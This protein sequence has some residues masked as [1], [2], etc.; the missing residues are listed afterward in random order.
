LASSAF[1]RPVTELGKARGVGRLA[2]DEFGY[3]MVDAEDGNI[4]VV[5]MN[6]VLAELATDRID[7][8]KCDI[9]GAEQEF[10]DNG[11]A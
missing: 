5:T 9:E 4:E 3:S 10:F 11:S 7:L 8:L 2:G 6:R 1:S